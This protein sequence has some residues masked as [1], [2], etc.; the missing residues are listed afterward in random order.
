MAR[1]RFRL[2]NILNIKLKMETQ[3]RQEFANARKALDREEEH[4]AMLQRR[5]EEIQREGV[6]LR[7]GV[8]DFHAIR[9][10]E[11][12]RML[13]EQRIREQQIVIKRAG[14]VLEKAR[15][16]LEDAIKERKIYERLRERAFDEFMVEENRAESKVIDELTT[17]TYGQKG[18]Q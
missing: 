4:L 18:A 7:S 12:G 1:F 5:G 14:A 11:T 10:N 8:L 17:Y 3:A 9:D 15:Q 6:E 2:Q 16:N 13:N